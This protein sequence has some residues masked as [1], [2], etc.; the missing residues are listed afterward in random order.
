MLINKIVINGQE[1]ELDLTGA[2]PETAAAGLAA[3]LGRYANQRRNSE[4]QSQKQAGAQI[5]GG[6]AT[7]AAKQAIE[8]ILRNDFGRQANGSGPSL[9]VPAAWAQAEALA[10][11][12][13]LRARVQAL[14]TR[15]RGEKVADYTKRIDAL[16]A[17]LVAK[18]NA[19]A[20]LRKLMATATAAVPAEAREAVT[21]LAL[22]SLGISDAAMA[23]AAAKLADVDVVEILAWRATR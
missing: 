12:N 18:T 16:V 23:A 5:D 15:K 2:T 10:W 14:N 13:A 1:V 4:I 19:E 21:A 3:F 9:P 11:T 8:R 17:P 6:K 7:L 20:A 22:E